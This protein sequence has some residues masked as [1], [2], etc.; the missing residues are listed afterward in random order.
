MSH[1]LTNQ[2]NRASNYMKDHKVAVG[3]FLAA[4][5]V[6]YLS[7]VIMSGWTISDWGRDI[8]VYPPSALNTL[9]PRSFI[10]PIFFIT[11]FP[12]LIIGTAILCF[13]SIRGLHSEVIDDKEHVSILLTAFG[14]TYQVIGAWPLGSMVDFPW[15]WQKQI[16]SYGSSFAW[17][18]YLLSLIVLVVGGVSLYIHSRIYHQSHHGL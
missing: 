18:L 6:F 2:T 13:Y 17:A 16:V 1:K 10:T 15:Q 11:S 12:S 4:Y 5:G 9:L 3:V 14:F 7:V 8:T